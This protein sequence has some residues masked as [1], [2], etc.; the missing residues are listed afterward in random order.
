M[1]QMLRAESDIEVLEDI[2]LVV[3]DQSPHDAG[4]DSGAQIENTEWGTILSWYQALANLPSFEF[5]RRFFSTAL[6]DRILELLAEC[7]DNSALELRR[8]FLVT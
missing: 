7:S 4:P 8:R 1:D 5:S 2:L 6:I 3:T